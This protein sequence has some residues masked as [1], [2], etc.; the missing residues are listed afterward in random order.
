[1]YNETGSPLGDDAAQETITDE[2]PFWPITPVG[3]VGN[4]AGVTALE[5]AELEEFPFPL[6]ATTDTVY[7][8]PLVKPVIVQVNVAVPVVEQTAPPGVAVA[9]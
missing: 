1:V 3:A 8:V 7:D 6:N 2:S 9:R 5:G 4:P